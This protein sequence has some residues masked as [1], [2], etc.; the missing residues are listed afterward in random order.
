MNRKTKGRLAEAAVL[1]HAIKLGYEPYMPFCDN[2]KYD[3]L[4]LIDSKPYKVTIKFTSVRT[5]SGKWHVELRQISRR[6][7]SNVHI[8]KFNPDAYDIL[9][10]YIEPED[11]VELIPCNFNNRSGIDID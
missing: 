9:A 10:V 6:N 7:D 1:K 4:L 8:D 5:P 2:A 3:M 11:R